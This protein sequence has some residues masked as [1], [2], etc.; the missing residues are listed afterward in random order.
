M[1]VVAVTS[2]DE[3]N[4]AAVFETLNDR[5]IG[6]STPDLLR[7]FLLRRSPK[8]DQGRIVE[9]WQR[10]L[11]INEEASVDEYLRHYWVSQYGDVKTRKLYREIKDTIER[12]NTPSIE[13]SINLAET[14]SVYRNIANADAESSELA[15]TLEAVRAL[16]AKVLYPALLSGYAAC[17]IDQEMAK[18]EVFA[19]ALLTLYVR[20]NVIGGRE[21]TILEKRSL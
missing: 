16:G 17:D 14:A 6:L 20:Y 13:L 7:N 3:D 8:Q 9:A 10:V 11:S 4:A 15:R 18:L 21:T 12:Q 1:S 5:G 2:S 19:K